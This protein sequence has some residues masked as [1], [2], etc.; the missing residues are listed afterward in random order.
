MRY[1]EKYFSI[2]GAYGYSNFSEGNITLQELKE[3]CM[4]DK[5]TY[6][7]NTLIGYEYS[8]ENKEIGIVYYMP[9]K[10]RL[11]KINIKIENIS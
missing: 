11:A 9:R 10:E 3:H 1:P 8:G 6:D 2:F 5:S 4:F 7:Y